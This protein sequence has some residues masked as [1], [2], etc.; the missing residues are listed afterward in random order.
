MTKTTTEDRDGF[1]ITTVDYTASEDEHVWIAQAGK[2]ENPFGS[3]YFDGYSLEWVDGWVDDNTCVHSWLFSSPILG[4]GLAEQTCI[5]C[6]AR[7]MFRSTDQ[8]QVG[9]LY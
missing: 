7:R 5:N 8:T 1:R 4:N 2:I 6:F 9:E 3:V